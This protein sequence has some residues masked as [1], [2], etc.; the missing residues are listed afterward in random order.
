MWG[1]R[2]R[3]CYQNEPGRWEVHVLEFKWIGDAIAYVENSLGGYI[4]SGYEVYRVNG[5]ETEDASD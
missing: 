3:F 5:E 1:L 4:G 2:R